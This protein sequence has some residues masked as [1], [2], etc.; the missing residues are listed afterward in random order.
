MRHSIQSVLWPLWLS[1]LAQAATVSQW[2]DRSIYQIMTDRFALSNG[3]TTAPCSVQKS[4]YCGG[5]WQ[6]V[7]AKLDYIQGMGFDAVWISPVT[8]NIEG[9]TPF[10]Q[11]YHGYWQSDL[12]TLNQH[13]GTPGDLQALSHA[14]HSRGMVCGASSCAA[15]SAIRAMLMQ[16]PVPDGRCRCQSQCLVRPARNG[17]LF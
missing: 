3:S 15:A 16:S 9:D 4:S 7:I 6:G 10:G 5:S 1:L 2:R 12:Y 14:L 13:F 11:A 8:R 17:Q